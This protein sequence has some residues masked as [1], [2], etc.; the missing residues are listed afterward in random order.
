MRAHY[1]TRGYFPSCSPKSEA[2]SVI[3][4]WPLRTLAAAALFAGLAA[5]TAGPNYQRPAVET[6]AAF[7]E[8]GNWKQAEPRELEPR[9]KWWEIYGDPLLGGL[10]EQVSVSNQNL[11]RAEAQ[12]RQALALLDSSRAG[13]FPSVT[14]GLSS[15]R[16]RASA[17][18]IAQ[19][20]A[21]PVSRGV[22]TNHNLP[23][24]ASWAPDVWGNISRA[25][26][27]GEA[28]VKASAGDLEAARLSAQAAL[29][30]SYFQLRAIDAQQLLLEDTVAAYDKSL[31][32]VQNQYAAGIVAKADVVQATTQIRTTRA[33]AIDLGVQRAALEHAIALLVGKPPSAL[34]IPRAPLVVA[35][36]RIP[37]ALPSTLLE[38]RPDIAA[39]ERRMAQANA[40][41][42]VAKA[43]YFPALTLSASAG[44][45]SA[46]MADWLTMPSR[47][48]SIGPSI[49]QNLFDGGLR[50]AQTAQA[51][52]AY[53]A[54]V[55]AYRQTVLAG[56]QQVEDNLAA[57]RILAEEAEEQD[58]AVK[59]AEQSLALALNQY[60]AGT[61]SYLNVV[62]AQTTALANQRAAVDLLSR[63]VNASVQLITALGGGWTAR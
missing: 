42:G 21:T 46:T 37:A 48:W 47:F 10:L 40:Q 18:T 33:Q 59:S 45:Q 39:A 35:V 26:E 15:T 38:R 55:A 28:G 23:F 51:I 41:I 7:K 60:K 4:K 17:T 25:V 27:A 20:S 32:L 5:C 16:S 14:G 56:F 31:K 3:L 22:V 12:Y 44:Y 1:K 52:A 57:L 9:G 13:F 58:E 30:Q 54:N 8:Q 6:P 43:A 61:V 11:A 62:V 19:P 24:Q 49:A 34:S 50:R 63:R 29:A 2:I 53:D 36:P